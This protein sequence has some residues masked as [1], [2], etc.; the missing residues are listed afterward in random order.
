VFAPGDAWFRTGDLMR[1]DAQGFFYFVDRVGDTYRWKGENVSTGEVTAVITGCPGVTDAAVYGVA[2]AGADG[3]AGMAALVVDSQF[4]LTVL[5]D[6]LAARLP[7][8]ARPLFLRIVPAI[9]L[10]GT[11]KLRKQELAAEGY[12]R[13]RISDA[14]YFDDRQ[15][16]AYVP[17]DEALYARLQAGKVRV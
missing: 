4:E 10:T 6:H 13:L 7:D 1:K 12:D 8:Y 3:R 16:R 11:F 14:V 9:E 15:Q 17:L 2:V 5:R